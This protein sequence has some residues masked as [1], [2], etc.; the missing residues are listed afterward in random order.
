MAL[1]V[2]VLRDGLTDKGHGERHHDRRSDALH[3]PGSDQER[4][5][6]ARCRIEADASVNS[7]NSGKQQAAAAE[8]VAKPPDA[9][10][11]AGDGQQVGQYDPLDLLEGG[12]EG[13]RPAIGRPTLAMLVPSDDSSIDSDS[14]ASAQL[15]DGRSA[16]PEV[17]WISIACPLACVPEA[18]GAC[19]HFK[20]T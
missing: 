6:R 12:A 9:D 4:Q 19:C 20:F 2:F 1:P 10:D 13:L 3:R 18:R 15:A 7:G 17:D 16:G 8:D 11:Q 14:A 5:A